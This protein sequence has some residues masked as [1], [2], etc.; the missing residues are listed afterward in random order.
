[1]TPIESRHLIL[2]NDFLFPFFFSRAM[3]PTNHDGN[4]KRP[5]AAPQR[6][7]AGRVLS[8]GDLPFLTWGLPPVM[9]GSAEVAVLLQLNE[10]WVRDQTEHGDMPCMRPCGSPLYPTGLLLKWLYERHPN[11]AAKARGERRGR[12]L[13]RVDDAAGGGQS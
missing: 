4:N 7:E 2:A 1:M 6:A 11:R 9:K 5:G 12:N 3:K 8:E 10:G 13:T